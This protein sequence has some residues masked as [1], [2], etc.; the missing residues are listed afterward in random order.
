[1]TGHGID[2]DLFHPAPS[3]RVPGRLISVGRITAGKHPGRVLRL[4]AGLPDAC[5]LLWIG[6]PLTDADKQLAQSL[7]REIDVLRL[8]SRVSFHVASHEQ[9]P[10]LLQEADVFIHASDTGLDKALLEA[11]SAGCLALSTSPALADVLP[12]ECHCDPV[13]LIPAAKRLLALPDAERAALQQKL[14][15]I[16]ESQHGLSRLIALL[17][18]TMSR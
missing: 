7:Q 1:V 2:T 10:G 18:D 11:M 13:D 15:A 12:K 5:H 9:L 17:S 14:R 6:K 16:V 4:L 8:R 3:R